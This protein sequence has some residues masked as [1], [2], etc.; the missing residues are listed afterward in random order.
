MRWLHR[1]TNVNPAHVFLRLI[2]FKGATLQLGSEGGGHLVKDK[3]RASADDCAVFV[4]IGKAEVLWSA[5]APKYD[6]FPQFERKGGGTYLEDC[7]WSALGVAAPTI[8]GPK[9]LAG[10]Y[11]TR[12]VYSGAISSSR[13]SSVG[14]PLIRAKPRRRP[15][16][17]QTPWIGWRA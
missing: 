13:M 10:F 4:E 14:S 15:A 5:T 17:R 7:P 11:I 9:S 1:V 8:G 16:A 2:V 3:E 12:P 6:F